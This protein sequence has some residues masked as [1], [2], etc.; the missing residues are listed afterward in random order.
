MKKKLV[1]FSL[2]LIILL[3]ACGPSVQQT[4]TAP[5]PTPTAPE[6]GRTAEFQEVENDVQ[7]RASEDDSY[8]PAGVGQEM[9]IGGQ[10]R[11]GE[12]GRARLDLQPDAT[13]VRLGPNSQ[14]TLSELGQ[15]PQNPLT[16]L[17]L[18]AG[19]LWIILTGGELE[20]ETEVGIAGVRGSLMGVSY[21]PET[22]IMTVTC[23]EGNCYLRNDAGRTDLTDNEAS[24]ILGPDQAPTPARSLTPCELEAWLTYNPEVPDLLE[25]L[26]TLSPAPSKPSALP[27]TLVNNCS[28]NAYWIATGASGVIEQV[29]PPGQT[30]TGELPVGEYTITHWTGDLP[31]EFR[32]SSTINANTTKYSI[33][34]CSE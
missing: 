1:Y 5:A 33:V 3:A 17:Y 25:G 29:I 19:Q 32:S 24:G 6:E 23:L 27:Y 7:A 20:V 14:F 21:D 9:Q 11:S 10:A 16:R 2:M 13:I 8:T 28:E 26:P 31:E 18:A 15:E 4:A 12:E 34:F 30:I 22:K